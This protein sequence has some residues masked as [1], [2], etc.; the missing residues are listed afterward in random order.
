MNKHLLSLLS[1]LILLSVMISL[2]CACIANDNYP[3]IP[4]T[5][6]TITQEISTYDP[7][8]KCRIRTEFSYDSLET[9]DVPLVDEHILTQ[10]ESSHP[11]DEPL[12]F[13]Y[14]IP[15]KIHPGLQ[16]S[17]HSLEDDIKIWRVRIVSPG[18]LSLN[19]GFTNYHLPSGGC[20]FLYSPDFST[21]IG[22]YSDKDNAEHAQLWTPVINGE[23]VIIELTL[24]KSTTETLELEI[25]F[26]NHGYK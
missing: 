18:A 3:K 2:L 13:A 5:E 20:L 10:E 17:W 24:P 15:V 6:V 16:G 21:I 7:L 25:G 8:N 1:S 4:T 12:R 14:S 23:E 19:F 9:I 26:V 11:K 22:P